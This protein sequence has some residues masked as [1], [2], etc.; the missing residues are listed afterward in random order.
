MLVVALAKDVFIRLKTSENL[1]TSLPTTASIGMIGP[2][3]YLHV[4]DKQ[5]CSFQDSDSEEEIRVR[6]PFAYPNNLQALTTHRRSNQAQKT[7]AANKPLSHPTF[8]E[9]ITEA[10]TNLKERTGSSQY[11]ET[12]FIKE[13]HEDSPPTYRKLVKFTYQKAL[14]FAFED[15]FKRLFDFNKDKDGYWKWLA[16]DLASGARI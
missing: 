13:K 15:Y 8:A 10:I 9:M 6:V 7:A 11:A 1:Y 2:N 5:L 3:Q 12:K 16:G 14:N 4:K